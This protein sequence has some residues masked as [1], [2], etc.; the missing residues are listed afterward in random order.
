HGDNDPYH[1]WV[2][3]YD[4]ATLRQVA[5]FNA[6]PNGSRG[7][8]WQ[9]ANG[10][11][12]DSSGNIFVVTGNGTFD[13]NVGGVDFGNSFLKLS[14]NAGGLTLADFFTPFN[15]VFLSDNDLDLGSSGPLLLPD[16]TGTAHPHLVLGA[17]KD[18]NGYLVD[19]DNMGHFS[20]TDNNRIVQ[21][22]P[23]SVNGIF[24]SPAFWRNNVYF[25]PRDDFLKAFQ[26]SGGLL[27]T[28]PT[29][30]SNTVFGFPG[31]VSP[32]VSANGS[33]NG[34][35]WV[36]D[37]SAFDISGPAVLHAYDPIN[38]SQELYNS[39]QAGDRDLAGP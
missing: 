17:G 26:L 6:T 16:Q 2:L 9:S 13:A 14:A 3:G 18:G 15:H 30:Q 33:T 7:G 22:I 5:V 8:I 4:A 32:A 11:A 1:G 39:T 24:G 31:A 21:T 10:P 25:V 29:S 34:I 27:S 19:R 35:V 28:T 37:T 23:V 20:P 12:A 36:L 38:V